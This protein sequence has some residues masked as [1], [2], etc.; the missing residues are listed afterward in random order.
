[1]IYVCLQIAQYVALASTCIFVILE[2]WKYELP[3][4]V[5]ELMLYI[6][7]VVANYM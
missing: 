3:L 7:T 4:I 1:M 6:L 2:E 5:I